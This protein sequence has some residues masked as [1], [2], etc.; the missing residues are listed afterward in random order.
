MYNAQEK[1][2]KSLFWGIQEVLRNL[3]QTSSTQV[4]IKSTGA[5][6]EEKTQILLYTLK[7]KRKLGYCICCEVHLEW[8][9]EEKESSKNHKYVSI[10]RKHTCCVQ[11][12]QRCNN[13]TTTKVWKM[14]DL[15]KARYQDKTWAT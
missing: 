2:L 13:W 12:F 1:L 8:R 10:F 6:L 3:R 5:L 14:I 15:R 4:S 7:L 11:R 9:G